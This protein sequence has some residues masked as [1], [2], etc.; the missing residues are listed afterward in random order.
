MTLAP[1]PPKSGPATSLKVATYNVHGCVGR[2]GLKPERV[3]DVIASLDCDVIGIQ[4]IDVHRP[5]SG[6]IDQLTLIARRLGYQAVFGPAWECDV[7][8]AYGNAVLSRFP[9]VESCTHPLPEHSGRRCEP[10]SL[11]E[12][13]VETPRG[14]ITVWNTHLG[15]RGFEREAQ[16]RALIDR[17]HEVL[18]SDDAPLVLLGDL[19]ARP[20]APFMR[21]LGHVLSDSRRASGAR[22]PT[23]PAWWP[24][25]ALDHIFVSSPLRVVDLR[26]DRTSLG[27]VAS[28]HLPLAATVEW[29]ASEV[30]HPPAHGKAA[31]GGPPPGADPAAPEQPSFT[32]E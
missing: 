4:E 6:A 31:A 28:D 5:R 2:G 24:I 7:N 11:M 15:V 27:A 8:G 17:A 1:A 20:G 12:V 26:T 18:A 32:E 30:A 25:L 13:R 9:I 16:G 14:E 10:R 29:T 21:A 22:A 19:N 23:Y 3:A